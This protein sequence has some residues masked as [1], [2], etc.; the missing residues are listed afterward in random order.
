MSIEEGMARKEHSLDLVEISNEDF[1]IKFRQIAYN[2]AKTRGFVTSDDI[3]DSAASMDIAP[4]NSKAWGAVIRG[5]A[6]E[7]TGKMVKSRF[8]TNNAR[9]INQYR[10]ADPIQPQGKKPIHVSA[11]TRRTVRTFEDQEPLPFEDK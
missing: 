5:H 11:H 10:L 1:I 6:F 4:K 2:I 3:R 9:K 7:F 8:T